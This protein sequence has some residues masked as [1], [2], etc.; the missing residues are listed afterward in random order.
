MKPEKI[1]SIAS[2]IFRHFWKVLALLVLLGAFYLARS[3]VV[4][5]FGAFQCEKAPTNDIY[6]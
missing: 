1:K 6:K 3:G 2:I 5:K 4:I